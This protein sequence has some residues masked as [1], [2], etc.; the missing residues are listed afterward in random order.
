MN[1]GI[2]NNAYQCTFRGCKNCH[3]VSGVKSLDFCR[4]QQMKSLADPLSVEICIRLRR[5]ILMFPTFEKS[6]E[7]LCGTFTN[8]L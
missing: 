3:L 8:V 7:L 5:Y 4:K 2:S 1:N 6:I